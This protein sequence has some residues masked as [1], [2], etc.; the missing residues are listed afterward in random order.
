MVFVLDP[1]RGIGSSRLDIA[2]EVWR[3]AERNVLGCRDTDLFDLSALEVLERLRRNVDLRPSKRDTRIR[4]N[5]AMVP[6]T[7]QNM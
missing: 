3:P 1:P 2:I 7:R 6:S 4:V 5:A